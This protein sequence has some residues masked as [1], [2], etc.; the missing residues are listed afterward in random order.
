MRVEV[1]MKP[2]EEFHVSSWWATSPEF[3]LNALR[4]QLEAASAVWPTLADFKLD[5]PRSRS[6]AERGA[7]GG[8]ARA[9]VLSPERRSEIASDA[10]KARWGTDT[11]A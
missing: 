7:S 5:K 3:V 2:E 6:K 4:K 10:A 11:G 9:G 8:R 1:N